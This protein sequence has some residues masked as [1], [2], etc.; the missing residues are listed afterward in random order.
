MADNQNKLPLN[1]EYLISQFKNFFKAISEKVN[2]SYNSDD[3]NPISG[4]GVNNAINTLKTIGASNISANKTIKNWS[5]TNGI[6]NIE[7]Q[8]I[9][10]ERTQVNNLKIKN[11]YT[12]DTKTLNITI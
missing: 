1:K 11:E 8:D 7:T 12:S 2:H 10:I 3:E 5:E 9:S 4:K 6:I